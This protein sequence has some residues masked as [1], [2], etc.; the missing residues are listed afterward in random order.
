MSSVENLWTYTPEHQETQWASLWV[1]PDRLHTKPIWPFTAA[2]VVERL[3]RWLVCLDSGFQFEPNPT[4]SNDHYVAMKMRDHAQA[5]AVAMLGR[6]AA[7][8]LLDEK[9]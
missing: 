4:V 9:G 1:T 8:T 5:F 2:E 3:N 7:Q 6:M